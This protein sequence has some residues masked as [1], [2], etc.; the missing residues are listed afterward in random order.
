MHFTL[1][2]VSV[3]TVESPFGWI[4]VMVL[5]FQCSGFSVVCS[6]Y[7]Y[8]YYC[9]CCCCCECYCNWLQVVS[10]MNPWCTRTSSKLYSFYL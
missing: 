8:Y 10:C 9:C 1:G 4:V 2:F 6:K 5:S 7:Y 3:L